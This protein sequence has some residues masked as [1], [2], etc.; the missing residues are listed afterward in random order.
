MS[1]VRIRKRRGRG[2]DAQL[3]LRFLLQRVFSNRLEG[4]FDVDG[5][6]GRGLKVGNVAFR[7]APR[8]GTL[9]SHLRKGHDIQRLIVHCSAVTPNLPFALLDINL[10]AQY[11]EREV[12]GIVR[13]SLNEEFVAPAVEGLERLCA[14]HVIYKYA[15][16]GSTV[17]RDS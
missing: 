17:E 11:N 12:L 16:I 7:L 1:W 4:L 8:H 6:L 10:V 9:L 14:V 5:F 3:L 2:E 15:A 13:A